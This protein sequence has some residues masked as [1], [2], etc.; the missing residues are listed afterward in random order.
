MDKI[1]F[2]WSRDLKTWQMKLEENY[3][4]TENL[5]LSGFISYKF[6]ISKDVVGKCEVR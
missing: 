5:K 1:Y 2:I 6:K 3:A 4:I